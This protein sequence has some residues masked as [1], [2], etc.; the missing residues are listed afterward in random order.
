MGKHASTGPGKVTTDRRVPVGGVRA[1]LSNYDIDVDTPKPEH[2]AFLDSRVVPVLV[3]KRARIFLQGSASRTGSD[4][5]NLAL[6][7]RRAEKVA[8]HLIS[9][10]A[11]SRQIQI[12]AVGESLANPRTPEN[13]NDRAV[14][15]LAAPLFQLPPP[16][17]PPE[18]K[19]NPPTATQFE[20]RM[21]GGLQGGAGPVAVDQL[22][23]E[24]LDRSHL[25]TSVY[26]YSA[27]GG[28]RGGLPISVTLRGPW[29]SFATTG[30]LGIT[31][32]AGAARFT[33]GGAASFSINFLNM[34]GLPRSI[35]TNPN[36]L[37]IETG[38]TVGVG[39]STS[40]GTLILQFTGPFSGP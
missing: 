4:A 12:D 7:R 37:R 26:V 16:R 20:I 14:A 24:I 21:L 9:R 28:G 39:A 25:L 5:H 8:A 29:N 22:F 30:A 18:P 13:A 23:F 38:F 11:V 34:M 35:A 19:P 2:I 17:P 1:V 6:S 10:G 15:L 27:M 3:R 31:E 33:T 40:I 36:P 32:F